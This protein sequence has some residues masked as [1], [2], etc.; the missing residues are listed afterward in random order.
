MDDYDYDYDEYEDYTELI[1]AYMTGRVSPTSSTEEI[2]RCAIKVCQ[3]LRILINRDT[4]K[5]AV[6]LFL[7]IH[8]VATLWCSPSA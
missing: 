4:L 6:Q 3:E 1:V 8:K 7:D 5:N 2:I